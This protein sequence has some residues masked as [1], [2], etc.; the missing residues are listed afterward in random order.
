[1]TDQCH[2]ERSEESVFPQKRIPGG[3]TPL[4]GELSLQVT[5]GFIENAKCRVQNARLNK[6]RLVTVGNGLDRSAKGGTDCHT[7]FEGSQ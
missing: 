4:T 6:T 3:Q 7:F 2:S 5:E 1:M